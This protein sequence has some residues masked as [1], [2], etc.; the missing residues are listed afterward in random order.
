MSLEKINTAVALKYSPECPAPFVLAKG[1]NEL[2]AKLVQCAEQN[3]ILIKNHELLANSL[4]MLDPGEYIPEEFYEI[5]AEFYRFIL[6]V[7][8]DYE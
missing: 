5:V 7:E 2:A 4:Y 6:E 8:E 1:K 3:G